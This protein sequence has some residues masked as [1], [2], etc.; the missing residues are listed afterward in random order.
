MAKTNA[1]GHKMYFI[2][3][4]TNKLVAHLN[5]INISGSGNKIDFTTKDNDGFEDFDM[6]LLSFTLSIDGKVD[7]QPGT[8]NR[9]INDIVTAFRTRATKT[10]L[11]KN[12]LTGDTTYQGAVKIISFEITSGTEEAL[13]FSAELGFIGDLT[14]GVNA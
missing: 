14:V 2:E 9:N 3:T 6:G 7:F 8:N 10:V 4:A 11:I 13:A 1:S 5:N 12:S